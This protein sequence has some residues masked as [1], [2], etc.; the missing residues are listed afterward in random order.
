MVCVKCL[1]RS[2]FELTG[3]YLAENVDAYK[4]FLIRQALGFDDELFHFY[5]FDW[6]MTSN[7]F[8]KLLE[9]CATLII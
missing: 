9:V 7:Y 2:G 6:Y 5:V 4:D 1:C 8:D 3:Y